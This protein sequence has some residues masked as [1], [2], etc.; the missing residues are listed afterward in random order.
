LAKRQAFGE[1][2]VAR[3]LDSSYDH[4]KVEPKW[5]PEWVGKG[6]FKAD[7]NSDK[8]PYCLVIPPPNV[9]GA[10]HMGH[11]LTYAI[12]DCIIRWKRMSGYNT[13]WLPG[14]DHAGIA[15]QMLVERKLKEDGITRDQL[16]REAFL[17]KVWEWKDLYHARITEQSKRIG[18]SVDWDRE[19]FTLDEGVSKAVREA[20]VTLYEEGL[21]YRARRMVN[22][23][24][25]IRTVL[26]DLEVEHK[27][28]KGSFWYYRYPVVGEPGRALTIAT[29]RPETML[30][31]TAIAVHPDDE[32]YQDLIGKEVELPLTGR[33]IPVIGDPILADMEKGTGAVKVTPAHDPNDFECGLRNKLEF[34]E[35]FND[36]ATLND[37]APERYRGLD[38]F[39]A[40]KLVVEEL[41]AAGLMVKVEELTHSVGHCMRSGA[42]IEPKVSWQWF[43]KM[44]PPEDETSI[45]GAAIKAV[46]DGRIRFVPGH[47]DAEYFRWLRNIRDWCVSRQLWWGH[48]IPA[49]TCAD[50]KHVTV[51][52]IDV[53]TCSKCGSANVTQDPDVLDTWFSSGLWPFSTLGWPDQTKALETFYPNAI[54][55][56]GFDIIFFW[57]ARMIMMGMKLMG[58]IPFSEIYLHAMVRDEFGQKMSKTKG[59]VVDPLVVCKEYGADAL[60]F[61]LLALTAQGRD[62]KLSMKV[63]AGYRA[64]MNKIWNVSRF[65]LMNLDDEPYRHPREWKEQLT[66]EDRWILTRL[67]KTVADATTYLTEYRFNEYAS[68]LYQFTW[69]EFCDWYVELAKPALYGDD[70][71]AKQK[72]RDVCTFVLDSILRLMHPATPYITEEVW[73][74]LPSRSGETIV[75]AE[76]PQVDEELTFTDEAERFVA[77]IETISAIRSIRSQNGVPPSAQVE[78][79]VHPRDEGA[80]AILEWGKEFVVKLGRIAKLTID[81]QAVRPAQSGAAVTGG[82][83][84]FVALGEHVNIE[85]EVLR[86][87]KQVGKLED[88]VSAVSKKLNNPNFLERAPAEV[89]VKQENKK[90]ELKEQIAG[91]QE[92]LKSLGLE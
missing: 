21:L 37:N 50:C 87:R 30:G 75:L 76:F 61:A 56:T 78:V 15:T 88:K 4:N 13:L 70:E 32:R 35:I 90:T 3:E 54:M 72:T 18:I 12:Q 40:R 62:I 69:H 52:R 43:L 23:S 74:M 20:F 59:N 68:T 60:R 24:P 28:L 49:W 27:E 16:G 11:A 83:T 7:D 55:E 77:V 84:I 63:I 6:Y 79:L 46:E 5:Y 66:S 8:P 14:T 51:D 44:G 81:D 64:F 82:A 80:A 22:W 31:D 86:L 17:E 89:I 29:T 26:S 9:T 47:W 41:E 10:L 25:V 34:I 1:E 19:R 36:D 85:E 45:A 57:V 65:V 53:S 92:H 38:R 73:Q 33:T 48:R 39:A 42:L 58:E 67:Q 2:N 91:L 71:Q